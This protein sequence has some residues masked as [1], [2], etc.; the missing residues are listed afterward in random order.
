MSYCERKLQVCIPESGVA[1]HV[2][3]TVV[4]VV[5]VT[6]VVVVYIG[7][8]CQLAIAQ[9]PKDEAQTAVRAH[10]S[11]GRSRGLLCRRRT[12]G[13]VQRSNY[14]DLAGKLLCV[15]LRSLAGS[16]LRYQPQT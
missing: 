2:P 8:S 5:M 12:R 16:G 9:F 3:S 10:T 4:A 13:Y 7:R 1:S 14:R 6:V 15:G 11:L